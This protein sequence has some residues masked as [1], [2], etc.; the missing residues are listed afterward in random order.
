MK[1]LSLG[2]LILCVILCFSLSALAEE[3]PVIRHLAPDDPRP[4][5]GQK[6]ML[7]VHF[8]NVASADCIL[9]RMNGQTLLIDSGRLQHA[10]R[11]LAYFEK[12]GVERLDYAFLSHPHGDHS[13]GYLSVLEEIPTDAFLYTAAYPGYTSDVMDGIL[14]ILAAKRIPMVSLTSGST[15]ELGGAALTFYDWPEPSSRAE[16]DRSMVLM[17]RYGER[18]ILFSADVEN[19]GQRA[20]A[21][22]Y[23]DAL[24]ADILKMPHHGLA[25][26]MS[27]FHEAVRPELATFSNTKS[28]IKPVL[29]TMRKR[30]VD[31]MLTTKGTIV[32]VTGGEAWEVWQI[33]NAAK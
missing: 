2:M 22:L 25:A 31:W 5:L 17:V 8:I 1:R 26:Y 24:R 18:S 10:D 19:N 7:E 28:N 21:E 30:G 9:L 33:P 12:I 16:N 11:I 27:E 3:A 4:P 29:E 32:A 15:L 13:G 23:G 6:G 14:E 20:L